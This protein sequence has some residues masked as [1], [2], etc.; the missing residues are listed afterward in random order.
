MRDI[1]KEI[2]N[3]KKD[4]AI[5]K[6]LMKEDLEFIRRTEEAYQRHEKGEFISM[7]A[8]KFLEELDKC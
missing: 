5:L 6:E 2:T 7:S 1:N 3:L 8:D 4:V